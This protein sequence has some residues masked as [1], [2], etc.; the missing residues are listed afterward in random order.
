MANIRKSSKRTRHIDIR[1]FALSDWVE[2]DLLKLEYVET[3]ANVSDSLTKPLGRI[4]FN[5]YTKK[6]MGHIV[7]SYISL[8]QKISL[9]RTINTIVLFYSSFLLYTVSV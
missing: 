9:S 6:I 2:H 4:L 1:H 8:T 3:S 7:P 5:R